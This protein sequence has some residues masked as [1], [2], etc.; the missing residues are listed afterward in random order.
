[1]NT[2]LFPLPISI[3]TL[4][5]SFAVSSYSQTIITFDDIP[6]NNGTATFLQN[7]YDGLVWNSF[8]VVNGILNPNINGH[9]TNGFYYGVVSLSNVAVL[10]FDG[11]SE[12]D[13]PGTN[14]NFLSAYLTGGWSSN[15]NI[16]VQGFDGTNLLYDTAVIASATNSTLFTFD[17]LNVNRLIFTGSG[18]LPAFDSA[19][20]TT[21][22]MDNFTFEFV[23]EPSSLLL[24]TAGAL[25]LC[26]FLK[27]RR[28]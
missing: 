6:K 24:A 17:Y 13:S 11:S 16:E 2:K 18:G 12:I 27:R 10:A 4:V 1:M 26:P 9:I 15:L 19:G 21:F 28:D 23:P 22:A 8:A 20:D 7:N 3:L 14:I 25:L 5:L